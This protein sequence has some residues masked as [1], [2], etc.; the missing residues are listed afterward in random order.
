MRP[1]DAG[2]GNGMRERLNYA[3]RVIATGLSFLSFGIGGVILWLLVFPLLSLLVRDLEVRSQKARAIIHRSFALFIGFMHRMGVL[4]YEIRGAERLER[5][6][7][8]VLANHPTL[9]DVVFLVSLIPNADCVVKSRLATNPFTRGPVRATRY[10]CNDNG[11]GLIEDCIASLRSGKNLIIFPEGTRTPRTG[12]A[13][14]QRGAANIAVRGLRDITPVIIRCS[15]PTLS[16]GEKWYRVPSRRFHVSIEVREDM[17]VAPF[18]AGTSEAQAARKLT[19][20]LTGYFD[21]E[22]PIAS[23]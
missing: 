7:L 20:H 4:T 21:L 5:R 15:P 6:G 8:L 12:P 13:T 10:I 22:R 19:E 2:A 18:L 16:K 1:V 17:P 14:L 9:I 3:W 23:A 11:A